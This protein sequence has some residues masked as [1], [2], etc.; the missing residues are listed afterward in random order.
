MVFASFAIGVIA[1]AMAI[2]SLRLGLMRW[3]HDEFLASREAFPFVVLIDVDGKRWW[4]VSNHGSRGI[5]P[6]SLEWVDVEPGQLAVDTTELPSFLAPGGQ[7][8][9]RAVGRADPGREIRVSFS[10]I[11]FRP[12]RRRGGDWQQRGYRTSATIDPTVHRSF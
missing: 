6:D 1:L 4:R 5:R 7:A 9:V 2:A 10:I 8:F 3:Q 12:W 11:T